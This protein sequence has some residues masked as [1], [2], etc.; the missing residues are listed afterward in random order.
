M[1]ERYVAEKVGIID[2]F[3]EREAICVTDTVHTVSFEVKDENVALRL[4]ELLN[5]QQSFIDL[6]FNEL[7]E[8]QK[9]GYVVN[10]LHKNEH[11][12]LIPKEIYDE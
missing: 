9:Q 7:V 8:A 12:S 3:G 4:C 10:F 11:C 6:L 2:T 5:E 1:S